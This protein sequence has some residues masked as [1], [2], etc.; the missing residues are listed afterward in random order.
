MDWNR[1]AS[2]RRWL[3]TDLANG[4]RQ[5]PC[6]GSCDPGTFP[7]HNRLRG[8]HVMEK[9]VGAYFCAPV[10][11]PQNQPKPGEEGVAWGPTG[12]HGEGG[13][14]ESTAQESSHLFSSSVKGNREEEERET[15]HSLGESIG[16]QSTRSRHKAAE[17]M[18]AAGSPGN[19]ARAPTSEP[20]PQVN[21]AFEGF[22]KRLCESE[23]TRGRRGTL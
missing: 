21:Q 12:R 3:G 1:G 9:A 19:G 8:S 14:K 20:S 18:D 7:G 13:M 16:G 23:P 17:T 5:V 4:C 15:R 10:C 2:W 11:L 6:R 22:Q